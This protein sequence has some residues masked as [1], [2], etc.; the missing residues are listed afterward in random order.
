MTLSKYIHNLHDYS[1]IVMLTKTVVTIVRGPAAENH[2]LRIL[3]YST[4]VPI[5][6]FIYCGLADCIFF[7]QCCMLT[8]QSSGSPDLI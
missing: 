8:A 7:V 1:L 5:M 2:I 3:L 4:V 6:Q